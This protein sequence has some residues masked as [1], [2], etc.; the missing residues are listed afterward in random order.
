MLD[1][2]FLSLLGGFSFAILD[3][4]EGAIS[5]MERRAP[6]LLI[7]LTVLHWLCC[8]GRDQGEDS[9]FNFPFSLC[10]TFPKT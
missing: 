3:V 4:V 6:L 7:L 8:R 9:L 1:K 5:I 2:V 10:L